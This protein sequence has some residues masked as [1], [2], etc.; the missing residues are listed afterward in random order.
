[1]NRRVILSCA[2]AALLSLGVAGLAS[3]EASFSFPDEGPNSRPIGALCE[4]H[5]DCDSGFCLTDR[6][7]SI[8]TNLCIDAC[9]SGLACQFFARSDGDPV[10][11]CL[12]P[13]CTPPE[14]LVL[15]PE[16][17][18]VFEGGVVELETVDMEPAPDLGSTPEGKVVHPDGFGG[19]SGGSVDGGCS[20]GA[21]GQAPGIMTVLMA[22]LWATCRRAGPKMAVGRG[23]R[24][25]QVG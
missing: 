17:P 18:P 11:V 19:A 2:A 9:P 4:S 7:P 16:Q 12:P 1:M 8:C 13:A 23:S 24:P 21:R 6:Q 15:Q 14:G 3:A 22:L 5:R 25:A 10:F 20:A